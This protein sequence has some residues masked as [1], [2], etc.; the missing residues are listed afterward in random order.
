MSILEPRLRQRG[1]AATD[2]ITSLGSAARPLWARIDADLADAGIEPSSLPDDLDQRA[3]V[4]E[5]A[6]SQSRAFRTSELVSE[7]HARHH[8]PDATEAFEEVVKADLLHVSQAG[9]A[10]LTL[11]PNIVP[12]AY[13][14]DIDFHRTLGGWDGHRMA[15]YIHG[16]IIHR[17]MV[18]RAFP[19]G[20]F[21]QRLSVA[22]SAPSDHYGRII[23]FGTSTGHFTHALQEAF[24]KADICGVDLSARALEHAARIADAHGFNWQLFQCAA[25]NTGFADDSFDLAASYILLHE[26]P[27]PAIYALFAE[28]FRLLRPG[29]DLLM[30]DVTRFADMNRLSVWKADHG[31]RFGGEPYWRESAS[32]DLAQVARD[33]G[34]EKVSA[35]GLF[36]HVV[37]G[38]K[39]Q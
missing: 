8:G 18:N 33:A 27:V 30:A 39:P 24:P 17:R 35:A 14:Q 20:I 28:A 2:F 26:M 25:E 5:Q 22:Q 7:W 1:R 15:G 16:E 21:R 29:G 38:R 9:P 37:Q 6:L 13:W 11:S 36:P 19:G 3:A 10:S 32:L 34:F 23:E 4:I 31:A 12:P